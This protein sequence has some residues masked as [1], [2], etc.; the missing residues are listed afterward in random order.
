MDSFSPPQNIVFDMI[1]ND[2]EAEYE[3]SVLVVTVLLF[4][5]R[6]LYFE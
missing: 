5:L 2:F 3:V 6:I 4:D 1:L